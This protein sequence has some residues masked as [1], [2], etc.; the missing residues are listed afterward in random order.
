MKILITSIL[1]FAL[2]F[3]AYVA[4]AGEKHHT[5]PINIDVQETTIQPII[6]GNTTI[7]EKSS[8]AALTGAQAQIQ[9]DKNIS[10]LQMGVG[11]YTYD[12]NEGFAVGAAKQIKEKAILNLTI[13]SENGKI[14]YGLGYNWSFK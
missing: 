2:L 5:Y 14:G 8:G 13:G 12:G 4:Y 10:G 11:V 9:F 1:G 3:L 6:Y 7:I